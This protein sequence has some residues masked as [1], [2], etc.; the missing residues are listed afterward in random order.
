M[1]K[2]RL[3]TSRNMRWT[4]RP[5]WVT[6]RLVGMCADRSL[7]RGQVI[8]HAPL[9]FDAGLGAHGGPD[10]GE[11]LSPGQSV[12]ILSEA[13]HLVEDDL[14]LVPENAVVALGEPLP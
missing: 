9:E 4:P 6:V 13:S 10:W 1:N 3:E 12:I 2:T 14:H 11:E 7:R 5:G 8:A